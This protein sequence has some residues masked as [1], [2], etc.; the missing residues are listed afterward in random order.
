M[1]PDTDTGTNAQGILP[2]FRFYHESLD[3]PK[4]QRLDPA[5]FKHWINILCVAARHHGKLPSNPDLAFALRI[6]EIALESLLDRLLIG[7]LIEVRKGGQNGSY[8]AP[9]GWDKRQY[10]SDSSSERVKRYRKRYK[11]VTVTPPD[12]DTDTETD[13]NPP[14]PR[15]RGR[16]NPVSKPDEVSDDVW[17]DFL[18]YRKRK[19]AEL[20]ATALKGLLREIDKAGWTIDAALTE[21]MARGWQSFKAEWVK[22]DGKQH[23]GIT[24]ALDRR[25][26]GP[27]GEA[28]RQ[29]AGPGGSDSGGTVARITAVR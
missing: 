6:D 19:R 28:G 18:A 9:H 8:I 4:V 22:G 17:D 15:K 1:K 10:K 25:I 24:G 11:P 14:T 21:C 27:A 26:G 12:T 16:K 23:N 5:T 3:D 29:L 2:W 13:N 7:G 20:T